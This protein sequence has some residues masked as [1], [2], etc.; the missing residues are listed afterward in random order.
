MTKREFLEKSRNIHGYKYEY[1]NINDI[2]LSNDII[3]IKFNN[4]IYQQ[5]VNKHLRGQCPDKKIKP[6]TKEELINTFV[7]IWGDKY[8]YSL[9]EYKNMRTK[10]KIIH[11]DI[12][13]EQ[14]IN[15]HLKKCPV[16]G[17]LNQE[18]FITKSKKKWNNKYDYSLVEF[19]N[20]N[21]KIKIIYDGIIY[22]QTPHNHLKYQPDKKIKLKSTEYFI[23]E[24]K[25][26]H[27]D[28]FDYSIVEYIN[29][30][31]KVNII[32]KKHGIFSQIPNSHLRGK[33]C[34][35]CNQSKGEFKV[36]KF[37][38]KHNIVYERQKKFEDCKNIFC[39]PFD[40]YIPSIRT[41][42]E[43]D[44]EQHYKPLDF[45]GG[46]ES[47]KKLKINDKIK[48]DYCEDNYINLI[49]IKYDVINIE[50]FLYN[51]LKTIINI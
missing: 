19:K 5:R 14:Y 22:E 38:L 32:C 18:I 10:I 25:I 33:G 30:R 48:E 2:V 47:F 6:K 21:T 15:S 1:L 3:E 35:S 17:F 37:L 12:I 13:Y 4:E 28:I 41:C 51:N 11:D 27:D 50:N 39:L 43:F 8:D 23:K 29:D 46:I 24:S 45:F 31:T 9:V 26:I 34:P 42:I 36:N 20:A 44:G 7:S 49:R 40:F 16:E